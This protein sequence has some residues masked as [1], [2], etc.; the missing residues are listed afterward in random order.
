MH[1]HLLAAL[2]LLSP[3][4]AAAQGE[5]HAWLFGSWTG[6]TLPPS[7]AG[8]APACYAAP[9]V[10]FTRDIVLRTTLLEP[11]YTQRIVETVRATP[12]AAE[13][14]FRPVPRAPGMFG[15]SPSAGGFG[16]GSADVLVVRR[17]GP[18]EIEF[19]G[20]TEFPAPLV[21]CPVP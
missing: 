11:T 13:F 16:C 17:K 8:D 19:P 20:C 18:H 7:N 5:P 21:R 15:Q 10:I 3:L 9:T 4:P 2:L 6:G 12:E 1:R 14:R